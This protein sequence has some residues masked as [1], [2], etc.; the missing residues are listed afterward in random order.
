MSLRP[1]PATPTLNGWG[2]DDFCNAFAVRQQTYSELCLQIG[3][4]NARVF[5]IFKSEFDKLKR[6]APYTETTSC[7]FVPKT[8]EYTEPSNQN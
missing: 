2:A 7:R 1:M 5:Q 8:L 6:L 4:Q 3:I